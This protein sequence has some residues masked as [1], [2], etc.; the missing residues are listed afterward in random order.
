MRA[1][2]LPAIVEWSRANGP[3]VRTVLW[4]QGCSLGCPGCFNPGTHE[5]RPRLEVS[6]TDL[7][8][9]LASVPPHIEG[10]TVSGGEP[11]E[12]PDAL[13]ELLSGVRQRTPL[14]TLVFSGYTLGEITRLPLGPPI[15][16]A[17]D[18]VIAG[19]YVEARRLARG[20]RGSSNKTVHLLT[21]RYRMEDVES[22]PEAE[23]W[24]DSEGSVSLS[25]IAPV[26]L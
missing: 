2:N 24:I 25:G 14:S 21:D 4:F 19:R 23:V 16:S 15:L 8:D 1:L 3:G 10:I 17:I 13:L 5:L 18:V 22:V 7:L 11:F 6:V 20:L 26:W 12:Q 9:R